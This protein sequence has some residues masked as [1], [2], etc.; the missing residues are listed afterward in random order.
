MEQMRRDLWGEGCYNMTLSMYKLRDDR[1][2]RSKGT[3]ERRH[4]SYEIAGGED[5][6]AIET[7]LGKFDAPSVRVLRPLQRAAGR[8]HPHRAVTRGQTG[9]LHRQ[10]AVQQ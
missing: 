5:G 10:Y 2:I 4:A 3:C 1:N 8:D 9:H 6:V 7:F